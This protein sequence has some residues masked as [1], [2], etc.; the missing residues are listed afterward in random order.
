[1]IDKSGGVFF[2]E[3]GQYHQLIDYYEGEYLF[4]RALEVVDYAILQ[5]SLSLNFH[6]RKAEILLQSGLAE[7]ALAT[8]DKVD[9]LVPDCLTA[10]LLRAEGFAA[11][12]MHAE[13][14]D[15][16]EELQAEVKGNDLSKVYT[17]QAL[18]YHYQKQYEREYHMLA[19]ALRIDSNN[20]EALSR[21][22]YC[23][24]TARKHQES[25][26]LHK[27]IIDEN[28]FSSLAWYNLGASQQ[29]LAN[30]EEAIEA[31]EYAFLTNPDFAFAYRACAE[32]CMDIKDY[33]RALNCYQDLIERCEPDD[34]LFLCIGKCYVHLGNYAVARTFFQRALLFN[35]LNDEA[36]FHIGTS[37]AGQKNWKDSISYFLKAIRINELNEEYFK[38]VGEAYFQIGNHK[39]AEIHLKA[40]AD[41]APELADYWIRLARFY[42]DTQRLEDALSVLDEAEEYTFGSELLYYR[43]AFLFKMGKKREALLVLEEALCEDFYAH[44]SMFHVMPIMATDSE[45][46]AVISIFQPE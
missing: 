45:V 30:H 22:W 25:V 28:P 12:D 4:E 24:E 31:Y 38:A 34:D 21:M 5:Y 2:P 13:A 41:I 23:V 40:A 26:Q 44:D 1:M 43:S 14:L 32:V 19:A 42:L 8:L 18:I 33:R 36:L 9:F 29:Y 37:Y 11:L 17:H 39:D 27:M 15:L 20:K 3:E 7:Q 16:L 10:K 46:K 6:L 35:P